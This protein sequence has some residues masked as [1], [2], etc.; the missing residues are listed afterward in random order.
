MTYVEKT[1]YFDVAP[2]KKKLKNNFEWIS[3]VL[4]RFEN[5]P[6]FSNVLSIILSYV[7]S[8]VKFFQGILLDKSGLQHAN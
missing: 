5:E 7:R 3:Q 6:M 1:S 8:M 4:I 2:I